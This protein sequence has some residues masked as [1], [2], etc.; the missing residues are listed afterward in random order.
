VRGVIAAAATRDDPV[1]RQKLR[2]FDFVLS[3][4]L[5]V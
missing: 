2:R 4:H 3:L 1:S 5:L